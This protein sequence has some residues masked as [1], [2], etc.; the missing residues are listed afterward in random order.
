[1]SER[2]EISFSEFQVFTFGSEVELIRAFGSLEAAEQAWNRVREEFLRRWDLWGR[3]A[4][5][6]HFEPGIPQELR[7]GPHA[8]ITNEDAET[9]DRLERAR[10][11]HLVSLGIDPA[12]ARRFEPFEQL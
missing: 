8:I 6:W 3:P 5:W 2:V 11:R 9:W 12:A 4:A 7:S 10:R 1:M